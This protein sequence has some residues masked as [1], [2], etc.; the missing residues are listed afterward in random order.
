MKKRTKLSRHPTANKTTSTPLKLVL[1]FATGELIVVS[2]VSPLPPLLILLGQHPI[3]GLD[4]F[5][6]LALPSRAAP[7]SA[8][9]LRKKED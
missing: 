7:L 1:A 9:T 3:S 4:N 2:H 8:A 5:A 6:L